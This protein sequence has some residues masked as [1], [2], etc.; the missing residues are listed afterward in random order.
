MQLLFPRV[1]AAEAKFGCPFD[2]EGRRHRLAL[3]AL[4]LLEDLWPLR[5]GSAQKLLEAF[6][7]WQPRVDISIEFSRLID[8]L[9]V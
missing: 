4:Y 7:P 5:V 3:Q 2:L 6:G 9:V 8:V 1:R